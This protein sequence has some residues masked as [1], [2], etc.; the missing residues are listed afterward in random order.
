MQMIDSGIITAVV[1]RLQICSLCRRRLLHG[2][3]FHSFGFPQKLREELAKAGNGNGMFSNTCSLCFGLCGHFTSKDAE[4]AVVAEV[5]K[6]VK[7][8]GIDFSTFVLN[9]SHL[10]L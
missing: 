9:V 10:K 1:D 7:E 2:S 4:R 8:S 3:D 5:A 6:R